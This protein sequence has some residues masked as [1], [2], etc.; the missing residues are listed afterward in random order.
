[1]EVKYMSLISKNTTSRTKVTKLGYQ[2]VL[3]ITPLDLIF[4]QQ[5]ISS[6]VLEQAQ[7]KGE[8]PTTWFIDS[9]ALGI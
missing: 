7:A 8:Y 2:N 6:F 9:S 4:G 1:M 3:L 5:N